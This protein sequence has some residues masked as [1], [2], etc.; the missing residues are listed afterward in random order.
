VNSQRLIVITGLSGSGKTTAARVLED[1]G[2]YV[3]DNLP[4]VLLPRFLELT[5]WGEDDAPRVAVVMDVRSRKF[6]AAEWPK[7]LERTR[8][9][10]Y[11]V[12]I[13]FFDAADEDLIRRFSETR[14]R[15][16][17]VQQEG[18]PAAVQ[19]ERELLAEIRSVATA[20]F[21]SSGLSIHQLRQTIA[22][23]LNE[24]EDTGQAL[25]VNLQSFGY[26]YGL[27]LESDLVM[28]VRFL[29]NPHY[30]EALR[31][32]TGLDPSVRN[33]VLSQQNCREFL[34]HF[35]GML[36]FLL[37]LY[38]QEGKRY[39]TIAIGCTGGQ[40][41]SVAIVEDLRALFTQPGF[42]LDVR[43]RDLTKGQVK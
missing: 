42:S 14:R 28:D 13:W 4:P 40:H 37:P 34:S 15:H 8:A 20:V 30:Q 3:V 1:E 16:P 7:I 25:S 2:F 24:G 6:V 39:L 12:E 23:Y 10:G 17:L 41:R 27:P 43:H 18:V 19:R 9:D 21:D 26:R 33:F 22:R 29:P 38:Q 11:E 32:L 36:R 5:V 31:P 35:R